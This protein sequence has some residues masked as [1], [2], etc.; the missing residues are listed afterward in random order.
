MGTLRLEAPKPKAELD[1]FLEREGYHNLK[2]LYHPVS[3]C[4]CGGSLVAHSTLP[5]AF[6]HYQ[7]CVECGCLVLKYVLGQEGL[8]ELYGIRYFR[9]HQNAIGLPPLESR[10]HTDA[11]DRIPFWLQTIS[12]YCSVG[13]ILE[14]GSS[15]GRFLLEATRA[16]YRAIGLELDRSVAEWARR[17]S[18]GID[19][20]PVRIEDLQETGF[21]VVFAADVLEHV[22]SP[23]SFVVESARVLHSGG[24]ALFHTV[25]FDA[26]EMCPSSMAR[27]LFHTI[28]YSRRSLVNLQG[29]AFR[30]VGTLPG[31]FGCQFVVVKR[32][33]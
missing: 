10:W 22:Y 15:H 19:L 1:E 8:D 28:L 4:W 31:L 30:F 9:E 17:R 7:L 12:R 3:R 21:H 25:V 6:D 23:Y 24:H 20:R 11:L 32:T 5:A 26:P 29:A 18:D 13:S 2:R 14:I 27:P 33:P 16:G